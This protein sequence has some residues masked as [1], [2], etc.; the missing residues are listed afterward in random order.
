MGLDQNGIRFLF[1]AREL[2]VSFERTATLGRQSLDVSHPLLAWI[3]RDYGEPSSW[4]AAGR[5]LS[6]AEGYAEGLFTLLGCRELVTFDAS[7]YERAQVV[8]D[9]NTPVPPQFLDRFTA[10]LDGGSLE[11]IFDVPTALGNLMRMPDRSGHYLAISPVNN[12]AGHGFYQFSPEFF[13]RVLSP[14]NGY[15]MRRLFLFEEGWLKSWK[16]VADPASLGRRTSFINST[17]TYLAALAERTELTVPFEHP[18][19]QSDYQEQWRADTATAGGKGGLAQS[20]WLR[21]FHKFVPPRIRSLRRYPGPQFTS[22]KR[23][24]DER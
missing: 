11:H 2:G 14:E 16:E 17:P 21:G 9:F 23:E 5:L 15:S 18:P 24:N 20:R 6:E 4:A 3:L 12:F 22:Y 7:P 1:H 10:V 13:F 8:H 19:Q